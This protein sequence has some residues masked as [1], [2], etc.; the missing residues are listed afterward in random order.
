MKAIRSK[1][2]KLCVERAVC[3]LPALPT[4]VVKVVHETG[5][6]DPSPSKIE[7]FIASDQALTTKLLRVVNS[8]YYGLEAQVCSLQQAIVILGIQQVRN[9][10]LSVGLVSRFEA[11]SQTEKDLIE[12]FWLHAFGS[13]SATQLIA[14]YKRIEPRSVHLA[15]LGGLLHDIGKLFLLC[16]FPVEYSEIHAGAEHGQKTLS[17]IEREEIGM[18]HAE[19]GYQV[20]KHWKL[21]ITL[22]E[23]IRR[24]EGPFD[25]GAPEAELCV[26]LAGILCFCA[27]RDPQASGEA[28]GDPVALKWLDAPTPD[29][30]RLWRATAEALDEARTI[31]GIFLR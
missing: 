1:E 17:E 9:L 10:A 27:E 30:K 19:I 5:Q 7:E 18:D 24:H 16:N 25:A 13:A 26:H 6:A 3:E 12:Q 22:C 31:Y 8:A 29:L 15:Y 23:L 2:L 11:R 14:E 4:A 28:V 20:A 21:P